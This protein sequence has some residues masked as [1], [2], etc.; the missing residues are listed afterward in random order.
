MDI[1]GLIIMFVGAILF[2]GAKVIYLK[3]QKKVNNE[4]NSKTDDSEFLAL[5]NNGA[6]VVRTIGAIMV[7]T[8]GV[9]II[10]IK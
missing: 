10:F 5:V 1:I 8:G 6:V 7:I 9:F 3:N 2:F 4:L